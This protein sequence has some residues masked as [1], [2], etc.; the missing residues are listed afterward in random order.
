[1]PWFHLPSALFGISTACVVLTLFGALRLYSNW[2]MSDDLD[3]HIAIETVVSGIA[4]VV[5]ALLAGILLG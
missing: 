3:R 1:M 4:C 5:L 2:A